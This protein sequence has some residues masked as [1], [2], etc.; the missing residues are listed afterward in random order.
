[1]GGLSFSVDE[2]AE[3]FMQARQ[4]AVADALAQ[5]ELLTQAAGVSLGRVI[6]IS[7]G[8]AQQQPPRPQMARAMV[9]EA[10]DAVPVATGEQ[11]LSATETITWSIDNGSSYD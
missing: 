8:S 3:L 7:Q 9:M 1:M 2:P 11:E 10:A 4:A 6:S 5:A